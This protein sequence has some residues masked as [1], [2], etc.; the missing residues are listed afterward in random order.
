M[1]IAQNEGR[2]QDNQIGRSFSGRHILSEGTAKRL[3]SDVMG[4]YIEGFIIHW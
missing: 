3:V 1:P 4:S 2:E